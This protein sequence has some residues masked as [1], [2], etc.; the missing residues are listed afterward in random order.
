VGPLPNPTT[1][2]PTPE[3]HYLDVQQ[4]NR[5]TMNP[6]SL[7]AFRPRGLVNIVIVLLIY[8]FGDTLAERLAHPDDLRSESDWLESFRTT[9][10]PAL[11]RREEHLFRLMDSWAEKQKQ[12][13]PAHKSWLRAIDPLMVSL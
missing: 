5:T 7:L 1:I 6:A 8:R 3:L 4:Y 12:P 13:K 10:L 9:N 2:L 11:R